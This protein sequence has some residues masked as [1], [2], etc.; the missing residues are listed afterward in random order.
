MYM[1]VLVVHLYAAMGTQSSRLHALRM[2]K[3]AI[4]Q[5]HI[6]PDVAFQRAALLK[7][8]PPSTC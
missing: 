2:A 8:R 6:Q 1:S 3:T 4:L 7:L 5:T